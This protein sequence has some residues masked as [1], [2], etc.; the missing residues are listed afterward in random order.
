MR[1]KRDQLIEERDKLKNERKLLRAE[2]NELKMEIAHF[3]KNGEKNRYKIRQL[4]LIFDKE[5]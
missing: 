2:R 5:I 3:R 1:D 4:K